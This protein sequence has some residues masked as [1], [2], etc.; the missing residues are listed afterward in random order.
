M[1]DWQPQTW[2]LLFGLAVVLLSILA[3]LASIFSLR[4]LKDSLRQNQ[5]N[6]RKWTIIITLLNIIGALL[7]YW[8]VKKP[9]NRLKSQF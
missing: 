2:F 9:Q 1:P 6:L 8:R 7:Y 5:P 3:V 4:M